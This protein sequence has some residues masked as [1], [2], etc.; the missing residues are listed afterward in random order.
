MK[1][2]VV[3]LLFLCF[4]LTL[5]ACSDYISED[6]LNGKKVADDV[7]AAIAEFKDSE[8]AADA[9]ELLKSIKDSEVTEQFLEDLRNAKT[10]LEKS[11]IMEE[12]KQ[13]LAEAQ[14]N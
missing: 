6:G 2:F 11:Q 5:G 10:E 1:R 13:K 7:T 3:L 14:E 4:S 9:E 12:L 8:L